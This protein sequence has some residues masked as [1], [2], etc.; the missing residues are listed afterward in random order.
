M[1]KLDNCVKLFLSSASGI[2]QFD[3]FITLT[4]KKALGYHFIP[5]LKSFVMVD[6]LLLRKKNG[7]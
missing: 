2:A 4:S 5:T 6:L 7:C 3:N 1:L